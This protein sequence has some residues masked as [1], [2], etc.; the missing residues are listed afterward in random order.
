[1]CPYSRR[2]FL[3]S[4]LSLAGI[5]AGAG[6]A[7]WLARAAEEEG[8]VTLGRPEAAAPAAPKVSSSVKSSAKVAL[9]RCRGFGTE[10]H[11]AMAKAFDLVGGVAPLVRGKT[12]TVKINLTG[13]DFSRVFDRPVGDSYMTHPESALALASALFKAGAKRVRFVES[14]QRVELLEQTVLDAGWDVKAFES[15]GQVE[16]ANTRNLGGASKYATVKVPSGGYLFSEFTLNR[17]YEDTDVLVSLCK[18]KN[19]LTCG[20]TLAMKNIFGITPNALY[21]DEAPNEHATAGRGPLHNRKAYRGQG[22]MPGELKPTVADSAFLRV[23]RIVAD[24]NEARPIHLSVID[25]IV[26]MKGGEGPW[27]GDVKLTTPGVLIVG[28]NAVSAD[29]VGTA[30]MGYKDPRAVRGTVPFA[31]CDNHLL[32]AEQRGI[33]VLELGQIDMRGLSLRE[34]IYPYS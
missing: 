30:V 8:E 19:H 12:V 11:A 34:A 32:L 6:L 27:A 2:K 3:K 23:P 25:G 4:A 10:V 24:L 29:A 21:G 26:S 22:L 13:S 28:L 14:T 9:V 33:G 16:W 20:V 31:F 18:M 15:L 1:M 5:S 17:A 7:P